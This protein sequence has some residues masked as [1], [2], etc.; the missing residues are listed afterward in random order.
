M[1]MLVISTYLRLQKREGY[2]C[3]VI[4]G[5]IFCLEYPTRWG[6]NEKHVGGGKKYENKVNHSSSLHNVR[7]REEKKS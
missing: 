4:Q 6:K 1:Q 2:Y 5:F 3:R 7:Q